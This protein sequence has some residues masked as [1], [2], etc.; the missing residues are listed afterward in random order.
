MDISNQILRRQYVAHKGEDLLSQV[1]RVVIVVSPNSFIT[2]G[3]HPSG[4]VLAI[5][6]SQLSGAAW[7]PAFIEH[8]LKNDLLL[9]DPSLIKTIFVAAQNNMVIPGALFRDDD[10]AKHWLQASFHVGADE[11]INVCSI[12]K[13]AWFNCFSF[14]EVILS[15]FGKYT[16]DPK[17]LPLNLAHLRNGQSTENLLQCTVADTCAFATL[18]HKHTLHWHQTFEYQTP[19]DIAHRLGSACRFYGIELED[20]PVAISATSIDQHPVLKKLQQYFPATAM[21]KASISDIIS[22]EWSSTV[23]LFQQL[24]SCE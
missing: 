20:Y 4:E 19:E 22:P 2:A 12:A 17:V 10:T 5:N 24:Y 21:R 11:Q 6:S 7:N 14:P 8:E 15:V 18:H 23:H 1:F 9:A 3:Y 13:G 16:Q